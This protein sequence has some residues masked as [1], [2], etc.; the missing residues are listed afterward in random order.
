MAVDAGYTHNAGTRHADA[1]ADSVKH[2]GRLNELTLM[3]KSTGLFNIVGQ[4]KTLPSAINM[5]RAGKLPPLI[6]K[7]IPGVERIKKIF[8]RVGGRFK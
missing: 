4:L 8:Q 3:P 5:A 7:S 2:S 1:F 6:H